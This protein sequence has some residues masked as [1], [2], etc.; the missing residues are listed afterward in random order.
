LLES[1]VR[2]IKQV[3]VVFRCFA[4]CSCCSLSDMASEGCSRVPRTQSTL[5][6]CPQPTKVKVVH[7]TVLLMLFIM[8]CHAN[9]LHT[10]VSFVRCCV[11]TSPE[12]LC[13]SL[14]G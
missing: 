4:A 2:L 9:A 11:G 3:G 10:N 8:R 6:T 5:A 7:N 14:S 12:N 1:F 13:S